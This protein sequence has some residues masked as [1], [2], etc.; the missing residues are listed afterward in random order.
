[1]INLQSDSQNWCKSLG[2]YTKTSVD[3]Q[4]EIYNLHCV[5]DFGTDW[6][7]CDETERSTWILPYYI[8]LDIRPLNI[9]NTFQSDGRSAK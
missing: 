6:K 1:M 5:I 7:H 4:L 2:V 3:L 8:H 9:F